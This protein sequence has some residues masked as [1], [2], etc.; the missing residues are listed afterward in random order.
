MRV[1]SD[2]T[3]R[4][5]IAYKQSQNDKSWLELSRADEARERS[6]RFFTGGGS[7]LVDGS[8]IARTPGE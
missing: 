7:T 6:L 2:E 1:N 5:A 3:L 8:T 4:R